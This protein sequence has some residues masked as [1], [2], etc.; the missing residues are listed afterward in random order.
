MAFAALFFGLASY[1]LFLQVLPEGEWYVVL[2]RGLTVIVTGGL[3]GLLGWRMSSGT[4]S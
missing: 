4:D 2:A 1:A 3:A